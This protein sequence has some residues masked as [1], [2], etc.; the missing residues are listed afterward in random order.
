LQW[1]FPFLPRKKQEAGRKEEA[2]NVVGQRGPSTY[3]NEEREREQQQQQ[4]AS[5]RITSL[6]FI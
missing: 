1:L 5:K 2:S 6:P 3:V 4:K